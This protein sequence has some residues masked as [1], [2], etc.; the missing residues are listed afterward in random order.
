MKKRLKKCISLVLAVILFIGTFPAY[1]LADEGAE[2]TVRPTEPEELLC[3][4]LCE[5]IQA[6]V[7]V[8]AQDGTPVPVGEDG[9]HHLARGS[10]FYSAEAEGYASIDMCPFIVPADAEGD[11]EL[12]ISMTKLDEPAAEQAA[13]P[14]PGVGGAPSRTDSAIRVGLFAAR[15]GMYQVFDVQRSPTYPGGTQKSPNPFKVR[16]L[17]VPLDM[18]N[19]S[20]ED[21]FYFAGI[22]PA[23]VTGI[24]CADGWNTAAQDLDPYTVA[25]H[26]V[27]GKTDLELSRGVIGAL[28]NKGFLYEAGGKCLW[29]S[30]EK[31][32]YYASVGITYTPVEDG[33]LVCDENLLNTYKGQSMLKPAAD[34]PR[35]THVW[36][37]EAEGNEAVFT[38]EAAD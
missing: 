18:D 19:L 31:G 27:K 3:R 22:G 7:T 16:E 1:A 33:R 9:L 38:C 28:S 34:A 25:L 29:F 24:R 26:F 2:K 20:E 37:T 23:S 13:K 32:Y 5:E 4:F 6:E 12:R 30:N 14:E 11:Q 17:S 10:Y 36:S 8:Y 15:F 21:Y 35:H